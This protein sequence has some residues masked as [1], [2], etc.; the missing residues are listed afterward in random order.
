MLRHRR[1]GLFNKSQFGK[2]SNMLNEATT[3]T[4]RRLFF[5]LRAVA[6]VIQSTSRKSSPN[7]EG[8]ESTVVIH[9]FGS[10]SKRGFLQHRQ[11]SM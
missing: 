1:H 6:M 8:P 9:G 11:M 7:A 4:E 3:K 2:T 5:F 10:R